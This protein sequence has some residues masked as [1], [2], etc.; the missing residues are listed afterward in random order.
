MLKRAADENFQEV[1][2][3]NFG[4]ASCNVRLAGNIFEHL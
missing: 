3:C 2:F 4:E 1:R